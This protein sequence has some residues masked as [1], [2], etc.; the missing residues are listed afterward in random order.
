MSSFTVSSASRVT[1][2][3]A[4]RVASTRVRAK[5][6]KFAFAGDRR[7]RRDVARFASAAGGAEGAALRRRDLLAADVKAVSRAAR[8][9]RLRCCLHCWRRRPRP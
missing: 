1:A 5:T 4:T 9:R 3:A 8:R 6:S 7:P 2:R